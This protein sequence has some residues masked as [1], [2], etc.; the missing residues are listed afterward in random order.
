MFL[1]FITK[2]LSALNAPFARRHARTLKTVAVR[3]AQNG[4]RYLV[5]YVQQ[6][7]L[8]HHRNFPAR[9]HVARSHVRLG[10]D[11]RGSRP[12]ETLRTRLRSDEQDR[13]VPGAVQ[14]NPNGRRAE[15]V[16]RSI[17]GKLYVCFA[18]PRVFQGERK[19]REGGVAV[20]NEA[21]DVQSVRALG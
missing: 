9:N 11:D 5:R 6:R 16:R 4:H 17:A 8:E 13:C 18:L 7:R 2:P 21:A 12:N 1:I 14:S 15:E 3:T 19:A 10:V 20:E